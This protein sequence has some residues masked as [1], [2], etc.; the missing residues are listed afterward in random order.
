MV[1]RI[2]FVSIFQPGWGGGHGRVAQEMAEYFA[3]S[4]DAAHE[5][6]H[7]VALICPGDRTEL[8]TGPNGLRLFF[9]QSSG[10]GHLRIP[11]LTQANLRRVRAFLESFRPDVIH[12]HDPVL[13]SLMVQVWAQMAGVPFVYTAHEIPSK[14]LEFG[15]L[16][17][18]KFPVG[19]IEPV[20]QRFLADFYRNCDAVIALNPMVAGCIRD[21]GYRGR[22]LVIPNGRHLARYHACQPALLSQTPKVLIFVGFV[23]ERKHQLYL[24]KAMEHLPAGYCLRLIGEPLDPAYEQRLRDYAGQ[25]HL[26]NVEFY[27]RVRHEAMPAYYEAAHLVVSAS[28]IEVQSLVIIEALA[29][30]TPVVGLSNETIDELVDDTV[31]A[32][33]PK[34][35]SPAEFAAAVDR[36]GR[37]PQ[38]DYERRCEC[39]RERVKHLDWATVAGAMEAAYAALAG[40][41]TAARTARRAREPWPLAAVLKARQVPQRTWL[42]AGLTV[43]LS[44]LIYSWR[45]FGPRPACSGNRI[46][47]EKRL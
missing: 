38:A 30:G 24:L 42:F 37:L 4:H 46:Q 2:V 9:V 36:L 6:A 39:A 31:G 47:G 7:E 21:F 40:E 23:A 32:R 35:A 13:L 14:I 3:A 34:E 19:L 20:A 27:G 22:L 44:L 17:L 41:K 15:A 28:K 16:D 29:S 8:I 33:L 1:K 5:V 10:R 11:L 26:A 18:V 12:A 25:H 43:I 45:R